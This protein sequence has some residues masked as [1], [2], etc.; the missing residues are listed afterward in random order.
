MTAIV[1]PWVVGA[2]VFALFLNLLRLLR[3]PDLLDRVLALDTL[4]I[5]ALAL[6]V[7]LGLLFNTKVYFEA[8]LVVAMVG[9]IGTLVLAKFVARG[10]V[11][12]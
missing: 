9:F 10:N 4:Y 6:M 12:E 11:M 3:G 8:A 2:M 5:N 7:A 1:L